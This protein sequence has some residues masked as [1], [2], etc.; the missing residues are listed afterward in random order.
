MTERITQR[1]VL[2][3]LRL[4]DAPAMYAYR[5][6]PE[7]S[8]FQLWEPQ[9]VEEI[10][11][12]IGKLLEL[13][14]DTPGTWYQLAITLKE[15]GILIGDLGMHFPIE[16][17]QAEVGIT[18]DPAYQGQGYA[19]EA[20]ESVLAY[21]FVDLGK[22]RVYGRVD[23]RNEASIRLLERVGMRKEGHL[24]EAVWANGEWTDDAIYGILEQ[25]WQSHKPRQS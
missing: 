23:P 14:P 6:N 19:T 8:R 24:R 22:H 1:L 2:R 25:E 7:V 4:S 11:A 10:R 21:L 18:L 9:D 12:F 20:L 15:K 16:P 5:S 17:M 13:E 3:P